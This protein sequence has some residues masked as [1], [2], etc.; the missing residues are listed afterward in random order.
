MRYYGISS[1]T[2]DHDFWTGTEVAGLQLI[3]CVHYQ[4]WPLL[5]D[6]MVFIYKS[7]KV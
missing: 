1:G 2:N 4:V 5:A 3:D 6:V 7:T